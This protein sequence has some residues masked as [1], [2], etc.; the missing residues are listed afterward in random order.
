MLLKRQKTKIQSTLNL[1]I[2]QCFSANPRHVLLPSFRIES[3]ARIF[4][5]CTHLI[6]LR[7]S[8]TVFQLIS[9]VFYAP[10]PPHVSLSLFYT[11]SRV[12]KHE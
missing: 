6:I 12:T 4:V 2:L 11:K 7:E 1:T 3:P 10:P 9:R 8:N 5:K